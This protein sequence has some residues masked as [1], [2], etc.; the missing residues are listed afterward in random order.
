MVSFVIFIIFFF[1]RQTG[2]DEVQNVGICIE[3]SI[4][5]TY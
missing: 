5:L 1:D 2:N 3:E 4:S